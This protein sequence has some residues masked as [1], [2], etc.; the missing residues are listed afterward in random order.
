MA[1]CVTVPLGPA[2]VDITGVRGNDRNEIQFVLK[3]GTVPVDL[4]GLV[5]EAQARLN[6]TSAEEMDAVIT[7]LD[8]P[9]GKFSLRWPG[10]AVTTM[11]GDNPTWAGVW[12][13]QIGDGTSDPTTVIEGKLSAVMD[14]TRP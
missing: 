2:C 4:T 3:S 10:V 9:A 13:L 8:A 7:V 11:L 14:V 1:T 12:D 5:L 6:V